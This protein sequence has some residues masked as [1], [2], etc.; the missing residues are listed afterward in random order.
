MKYGSIGTTTDVD[1]G[2]EHLTGARRERSKMSLLDTFEERRD[3][4]RADVS[5]IS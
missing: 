5:F 1:P 2:G 4:R 3:E